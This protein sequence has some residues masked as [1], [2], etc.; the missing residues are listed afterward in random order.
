MSAMIETMQTL[1]LAASRSAGQLLV[2]RAEEVAAVLHGQDAAVIELVSAAYATHSSGDSSLPHSVFVFLPGQG[3]RIIALPAYLG[4]N[5]HA[6]GVKWISSVP[7]NVERGEDRASAVMVLND[8]DTGRAK[9]LL[10][11][12]VISAKRTAGS[13]VLASTLLQPEARRMAVIGCG[14]IGFEI[15]RMAVGALPQLRNFVI[16]DLH[17]E[18]ATAFAKKVAALSEHFKVEVASSLPDACA[19][20]DL[21][22]FATTTGQ[23]HVHDPGVFAPG[24]VVLHVS[25][26]DLAP[27]LIL[28]C[29]NVVD[30]ADHVCRANTSLHLTEKLTGNRDFIRCALGDILLKRVPARLDRNK[31]VIFSPFGLGVLDLALA[32]FVCDQTA[33]R[34]MGTLIPDFHPTPWRS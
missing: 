22:S 26:R 28:S 13:A 4:G 31:P 30:D 20:A 7:G 10:E 19:G 16:F 15:V 34:G 3:N 21:V 24:A 11:G 5:A 27:E 2:L 33:S 9:A 12:S 17:G 8:V 14:L 6:A 18:R 32:K 25:L 23:P 29:E 1:N